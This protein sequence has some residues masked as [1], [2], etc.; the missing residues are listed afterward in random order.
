MNQLADLSGIDFQAGTQALPIAFK[1]QGSGS[2]P[3]VRP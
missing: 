3:T 1:A 2:G